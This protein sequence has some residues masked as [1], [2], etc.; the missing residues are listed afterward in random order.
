MRTVHSRG[1]AVRRGGM[2]GGCLIALGIAAVLAIIAIVV[3]VMNAKGWAV[4]LSQKVAEMAID[5]ADLP[6]GEKQEMKV[7]IGQI[8][9]GVR[10]GDITMDEVKAVM[11][12][13][14]TSPAI[15]AGSVQFFD[16][17]YVQPSGLSEEEKAAG[18]LALNRF[19]QGMIAGS[20]TWDDAG[21]VL[22]PI[23]TL[24]AAGNENL[25]PPSQVTD[26]EIRTVIETARA[27]ADGAGVGPERVEVD[28]SEAFRESVERA[29][30]R[31]LGTPAGG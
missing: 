22:G 11:E 30:G 27:K 4:S 12:G 26:V 5:E 2:L 24:D 25:K 20:L 19:A 15:Y 10:S 7:V 21:E 6:E 16:A 28:V 9:D 1:H 17:Q 3:V 31:P 8:A 13:L 18:S 14:E 29:L 23:Q